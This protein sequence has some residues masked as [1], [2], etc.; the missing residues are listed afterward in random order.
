MSA[1]S[2]PVHRPQDEGGGETAPG[3]VPEPLS[4]EEA[5]RYWLAHVYQGDDARQL[6]F[7]AIVTG[8]L[9]G[10]VMSISNL[11]VGLTAR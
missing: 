7:R 1:H 9:I 8:M 3:V 11:Y 10:G 6:T 5:A 2:D 4:G